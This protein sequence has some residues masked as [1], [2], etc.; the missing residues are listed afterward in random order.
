M[1]KKTNRHDGCVYR[2]CCTKE[3]K[4]CPYLK[5]NRHTCNDYQTNYLYKEKK[6]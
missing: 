1:S 4:W 6:Q 3:D 5:N 2:H